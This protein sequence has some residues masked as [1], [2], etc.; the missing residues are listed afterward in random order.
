[1]FIWNVWLLYFRSKSHFLFLSY[2]IW[3]MLKKKKKKGSVSFLSPALVLPSPGAICK[4]T[5]LSLDT[6][7]FPP[8][9][10][11][12]KLYRKLLRFSVSFC[13]YQWIQSAA[14]LW[15]EGRGKVLCIYSSGSCILITLSALKGSS[16][17]I[18]L[19]WRPIK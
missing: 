8:K 7:L 14:F 13:V 3:K 11:I 2:S 1:M 15:S 19:D 17:S 6:W 4:A 16:D 9:K 12:L 5:V 10:C 18:H